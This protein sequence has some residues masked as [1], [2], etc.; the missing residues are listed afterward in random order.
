MSDTP[1]P[2]DADDV[3]EGKT[4]RSAD[5]WLKAIERA[6]RAFEPYQLRC[7]GVDKLYACLEHLANTGRDREFQMF[8]ANIEVLKPS[9]YSRP[10]VPVVVP[11]FKDGKAVN[12]VASELLERSTVTGFEM[13]DIN[14][15]MKLIRDD[16]V[17]NARGVSWVRYETKKEAGGTSERVCIE[18]ADRKDFVHDLARKWAEVDWVAKR[19]W[20]TRSK[21]RKRFGKISGKT[22]QSATYAVRKDDKDNGADDGASQAAV[23][24]IWSKSANKVFWVA[25][26]C[27]KILDEDKPHLT[28]EG[29]FPCPRPAYA[30]LQRRSLIP[31]PDVSFYKDQL[32][33]VNELTA[34]IATL[35]EAVKLRGF[36]PAGA[37]DLGDAIEAAVKNQADNVILVGVSNWAV[38]GSA[39]V[40]DSIVWLP[41]DMVAT[42]IKSL[43]ELRR[44]IIDD[45]Y[46]I[47]GLS[48]IMRGATVAS[49]T[50]GAQQLKSQYGS[51]RIRDRQEELIRV[52]RDLTRIVGEIMSE[53][54]SPKTLLD[55]SQMDIPNDADMARQIKPLEQQARQIEAQIRRELAD[56]ETKQ[57]A[58]ENP[59]QAQQIIEQAQGQVQALLSQAEKLREIPTVEKI[60][61][62]LRDQRL[63]PFALDIE[64]DST[65][66]P[67]ENAQKQRATEYLT[68]MGGLLAQ[69]MP[70]LTQMPEAG[71][72][73]GE[74]IRF[75]QQQFRVGRQMDQIVEEFVESLK[76]KAAGA[77]QAPDP[78]AAAAQAKMAEDAKSAEADRQ[79]KL[80]DAAIRKQESEVKA[81]KD[82]QAV[83]ERQAVAAHEEKSRAEDLD[84]KAMEAAIKRQALEDERQAAAERHQQEM[85]AGELK[86]EI[87]RAQ[88][89]KIVAG[90]V[91]GL[92]GNTVAGA[93]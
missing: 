4:P 39:A 12:R 57:L 6:Q 56:P 9:I 18:H 1:E 90:P 30:T 55:M 14:S 24:E 73:L 84:M 46:Q 11:R 28:L 25:E 61:D 69:A 54:F 34:R 45:I 23:W 71:P 26:G 3:A 86:L 49:E 40:K 17:I 41:L 63:R 83:Q 7:D 89:A 67:D 78:A 15:V 82:M 92:A 72:L 53:N 5:S 31:V 79:I 27:D 91:G 80:N 21:M 48:D 60:M 70:A 47:T 37:S 87:L 20:L 16:L 58:A 59:E 85:Q 38:T 93:A 75:A 8:W 77:G 32:E 2:D 65:I 10:P 51:I 52:A 76:A 35:T 19:S 33:E 62:L 68:A 43:I 81:A 64:T 36:Y 74:T 66:E 29:F 42:V 88:L 50:L 22:Y 44:Q 13:T